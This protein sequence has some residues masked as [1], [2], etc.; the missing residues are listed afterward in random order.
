[1]TLAVIVAACMGYIDI[2][3]WVVGVTWFFIGPIGNGLGFHRFFAHRQF[4][5]WRP[6]EVALAW[7]GTY[8]SYAPV[9]FWAGI[10]QQHHKTSD[11]P[12]DL[13]SPHH[14]GFMESF[15]W[16]RLREGAVKAV[17][18]KN[19]CVRKIL[20]DKFL[21]WISK[22]FVNIVYAIWAFW[23]IVDL[24]SFFSFSMLA[25]AYIIPVLIEQMRLN[26]VSSF[27][28]MKL[29][30]QYRPFETNDHT[31]NH[32]LLG[33]LTLGFGWHNAHHHN[34]RELN[35]AHN[36]WEVDVEGLIGKLLSKSTW[37]RND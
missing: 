20:R 3:W 21:M 30:G 4:E 17:D 9:L 11:T 37:Q 8:A 36:W 13:S 27:S 10:H 16:Y 25:S 26:S 29:P 1:M 19:Y 2:N 7:L 34:P 12:E 5:T 14:F 15:F 23:I 35:N 32:V 33:F 6:V 24:T 28:H 31:N 22:N 18:I